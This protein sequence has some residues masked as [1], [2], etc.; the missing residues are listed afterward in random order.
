LISRPYSWLGETFLGGAALRLAFIALIAYTHR[1][2]L[3]R[4]KV[5]RVSL[6]AHI[7]LARIWRLG[8]LGVHH[9]AH[10]RPCTRVR[11]R[12]FPEEVPRR[13]ANRAHLR[14]TC[15]VV[16]DYPERRL[17]IPNP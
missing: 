12:S 13:K 2:V 5:S 7:P 14:A 10:D 17:F 4:D 1:L 9:G 16:A 15:L 6:G 3:S 11:Q 8:V